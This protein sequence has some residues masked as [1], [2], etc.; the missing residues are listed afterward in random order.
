[1]KAWTLTSQKVNADPAVRDVI[2]NDAVDHLKRHGIIAGEEKIDED[3]L[4]EVLDEIFLRSS[5]ADGPLF[6]EDHETN[7]QLDQI[8]KGNYGDRPRQAEG[9]GV[10]G[11]PAAND[12]RR[13]RTMS[14]MM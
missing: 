10:V 13:K 8:A 2:G 5:Q 6:D 7:D 3:D 1:M 12:E 4:D 11:M 9:S 14:E